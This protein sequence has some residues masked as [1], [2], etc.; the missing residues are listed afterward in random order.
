MK[1][2]RLLFALCLAATAHAQ[3]PNRAIYTYQ[4]PD[5]DQ[6]LIEGA[7]KERELMLYSTMTV[8]D[9][10][11]M[12]AAFE[13]KY[14][15]R[16]NHWRGSAEGIVNR[17]VSEARA[18]RND[19]DVFETSAHRM[20][21]L[22][23]EKVLED[24]E[25]PSL[26]DI[27]PQAFP[28]GHRQY[29]AD[30]FVFVVMAWNTSQVK[31][32]EVPETYADL[33]QPRWMGRITVEGTD[34][35]W[36]AAVA[37]AMG[38]EKGI[39]YFKRLLAMKPQVRN[40]HIL[41]AQLVASGEVPFF[42]TAYNNNIETLKL[43]GAPVDWKPLQPAFGQASAIGVAKFAPHPYAA[44]LF[45]EFVLSKEGQEV[46]KSLNRVPTSALVDSPLNKFKYDIVRPTLA[47]DEGDK[48]DKLFSSLFLGGRAVQEGE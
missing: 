22:Y 8:N 40:S 12:G 5:R 32:E 1:P 23:R 47:L 14:G 15:I 44:L 6:R 13:K 48:W 30:R 31:R 21:A 28:R 3:S 45:T 2:I 34:V 19:V 10:K 27:V 7:K 38:E 4:G 41:V 33:L 20:E 43:K 11:A 35:L 17:G 16:L 25:T 42:L 18:K 29:V 46:Y 24:F 36:F 37:M 39:A 26:R 9:G